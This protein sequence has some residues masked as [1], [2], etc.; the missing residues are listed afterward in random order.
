MCFKDAIDGFEE[1]QG[2]EISEQAL[3]GYVLS[4]RYFCMH[5]GND[6]IED[7]TVDVIID[8]LSWF[9][10]L[11]FSK[12]TIIRKSMA[13]RKFFEFWKKQGYEVVD[14]EL[15]PLPKKEYNEPK[16]ATEEEYRALLGI[17]PEDKNHYTWIRNEAI[18]RLLWDTGMRVGELVE[19]KVKDLDLLKQSAIIKTEK[20]QGRKPLRR[21]FWTEPTN[22]ALERWIDKREELLSKTSYGGTDT[23]ILFIGIKPNRKNGPPVKKLR[24]NSIAQTFRT[25]SKKAELGRTVNPHSF[26]HHFG[27][28]LA[29][30][31]ANNSTISKL[32]GHS[33]LQSSYKYTDL[34]GEELESVYRKYKG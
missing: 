1:W 4:L 16:T 18:I 6:D 34:E 7:V 2:F 11:G 28:E 12:S 31:G 29:K 17:I 27:H 13:L 25:Y 14:K 24:G 32:L 20:S 3:N 26:R 33:S 22:G 21:I 10:K 8:W 15:I 19:L 30:K 9:K 23:D 5:I